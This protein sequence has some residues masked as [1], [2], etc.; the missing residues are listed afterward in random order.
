MTCIKYISIILL[1]FFI[2]NKTNYNLIAAGKSDRIK[3]NTITDYIDNS[4]RI[5]M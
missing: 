3:F 1:D 5:Y 4:E 2:D